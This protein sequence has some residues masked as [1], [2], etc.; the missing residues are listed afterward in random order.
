MEAAEAR[1]MTQEMTLVG[2]RG[3]VKKSQHMLYLC[4]DSFATSYRLD[5]KAACEFL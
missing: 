5:F 3:L 4:W 2:A 1:E